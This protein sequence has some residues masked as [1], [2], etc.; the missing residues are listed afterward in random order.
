MRNQLQSIST[1]VFEISEQTFLLDNTLRITLL[2]RQDGKGHLAKVTQ[3]IAKNIKAGFVEKDDM[4]V[5]YIQEKLY[6]M[7]VTFF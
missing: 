6:C 1:D 4:N 5:A 7:V 2:C 3:S